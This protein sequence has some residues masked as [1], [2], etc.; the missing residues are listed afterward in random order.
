MLAVLAWRNGRT[1]NT[2]CPVGTLL[3]LLSRWSLVAPVIDAEKCISCNKC[4]RNCKTACMDIPTTGIDYSRCV[5]C[6]D[7]STSARRTLSAFRLRSKAKAAAVPTDKGAAAKKAAAKPEVKAA[8]AVSPRASLRER[9]AGHVAVRAQEMKVDGGFAEIIAEGAQEKTRVSATGAQSRH[10]SGTARGA[11][12]VSRRAP[13]ACCV[14]RGGLMTLLQPEM[15][16]KARL[17]PPG[18]CCLLGGVPHG[19]NNQN[20]CSREVVD[21]GGPCR[22][23]PRELYR[24]AR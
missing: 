9:P 6:L 7:S 3:G 19:R 22:M 16:F 1:C 24:A 12:S 10:L 13:T 5:V 14:R 2:V 17:L 15:G 20:N 8:D 23:D 4:V 18:V 11:S 21:T